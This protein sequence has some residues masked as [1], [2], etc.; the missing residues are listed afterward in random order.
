MPLGVFLPTSAGDTQCKHS[1]VLCLLLLAITTSDLPANEH[2]CLA[3]AR[4]LFICFWGKLI[5][6]CS[7]SFNRRF[8]RHLGS[9]HTHLP[10]LPTFRCVLLSI[11]YCFNKLEKTSNQY[12]ECQ[13]CHGHGLHIQQLQARARPSHQEDRICRRIRHLVG[14]P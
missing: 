3:K 10:S 9:H 14:T 7:Y 12:E 8:C 4:E 11:K 5:Q 2:F 13:R 1:L 6:T